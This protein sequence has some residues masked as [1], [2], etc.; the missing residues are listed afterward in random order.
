ME[1]GWS[2]DGGHASMYFRWIMDGEWVEYGQITGGVR[3]EYGWS[4]GG[5]RVEYGWGMRC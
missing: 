3:V 2:L 4:T 1:S 5:V